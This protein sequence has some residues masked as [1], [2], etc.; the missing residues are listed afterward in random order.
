[1]QNKQHQHFGVPWLIL[2]ANFSISVHAAGQEIAKQEF[3]VE[4]SPTTRIDPEN[5]S[6]V[7]IFNDYLILGADEGVAIQVLK[8]NGPNSY[9]S[10]KAQLII[11]DKNAKEIDIEGIAAGEKF[12]YVVGSHSRK[13]LKIKPDKSVKKNRQRLATIKHEPSREQ[14]FRVELDDH[15]RLLNGAI[16]KV[17]LTDI[18]AKDSVL[19]LFQDIPSKENGIDIEGIAVNEQKHEIYIG[20]RG[21][22]LRGGFIPVMVLNLEHGKF[23]QNKLKHEIK[24]LNLDGL[25]IRGITRFVD[26]FLV[27]AGPVADQLASY[28]L[29]FWDGKDMVPGRD[30]P[31]EAQHIKRLCEIPLPNSK[32]KAE[33]VEFIELKDGKIHFLIVYDGEQNGGGVVFS[34]SS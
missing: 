34:C 29:F 2:I 7:A 30:R 1:M 21:P 13:R 11:L 16:K 6:G 22:V 27:I 28:Y 26:G 20:F 10:N 32:V 17:S 12:I 14:L 3:L 25:G 31:T 15:G 33:G 23:R 5:I 24:Y 8:N 18:I 9:L 4:I 19:A